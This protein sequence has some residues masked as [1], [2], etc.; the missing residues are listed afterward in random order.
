[1]ISILLTALTENFQKPWMVLAVNGTVLQ[2][3]GVT[4]AK[5]RKKFKL[6]KKFHAILIKKTKQTVSS[7]FVNVLNS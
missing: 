3:K 6:F 1:M 5:C 2:I 4:G 7:F